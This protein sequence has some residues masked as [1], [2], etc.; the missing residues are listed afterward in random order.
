MSGPLHR[1]ASGVL[2]PARNLH[3]ALGSVWTPPHTADAPE[4]PGEV[5]EHT[6]PRPVASHTEQLTPIL[7]R[8]QRP[9]VALQSEAHATPALLLPETAPINRNTS[10]LSSGPSAASHRVDPPAAISGS[11]VIPPAADTET[12]ADPN[13]D[14]TEV[15]SRSAFVPL[16]PE[17]RFVAPARALT[18]A[19]PVARERPTHAQ[20]IAQAAHQPD[21]IEI[22]IGRI[23]VT[24]PPASPAARPAPH[25]ARKSLD[26]GEYLKRERRSR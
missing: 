22:H 3:P 15:D 7:A 4:T 20:P 1:I 14:D 13:A 2:H 21:E 24:A 12:T 26:L 18:P 8:S 11:R 23:E 6:V 5:L 9:P 16:L 10:A 17:Q 25:P 19:L